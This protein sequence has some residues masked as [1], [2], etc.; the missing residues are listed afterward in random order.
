[1]I[2][3]IYIYFQVSCFNKVSRTSGIAANMVTRM[4]EPSPVKKPRIS[5]KAAD[6]SFLEYSARNCSAADFGRRFAQLRRDFFMPAPSSIQSSNS[7]VYPTA[8]SAV[9]KVDPFNRSRDRMLPITPPESPGLLCLP[10]PSIASKSRIFYPTQNESQISGQHTHYPEA[11]SSISAPSCDDISCFSGKRDHYPEVHSNAANG[12]P[13]DKRRLP[14][15]MLANEEAECLP[16]GGGCLQVEEEWERMLHSPI[17]GYR[18]GDKVKKS[19][20]AGSCLHEEQN[21]GDIC[22]VPKKEDSEPLQTAMSADDKFTSNRGGD[23]HKKSPVAKS[24]PAKEPN[25]RKIC[26]VPKRERGEPLKTAMNAE[27]EFTSTMSEENGKTFQ[28][29]DSL[30]PKGLD[31]EEICFVPKRGKNGPLKTAMS[32]DNDCK[33]NC[34]TRNDKD[35][36]EE[37]SDQ[38][39]QTQTTLE[40][41]ERN[42]ESSDDANTTDTDTKSSITDPC[43]LQDILLDDYYHCS[44]PKVKTEPLDT[45]T[46]RRHEKVACKIYGLL[47]VQG[48]RER[49]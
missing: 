48:T 3:K 22:L 24:L 30:L 13:N 31:N 39:Q 4:L 25:N 44:I 14:D 9:C 10:I 38:K 28:S 47:S 34:L 33:S 20:L 2:I 6:Q 49:R 18:E 21:N 43:P 32:A 15:A 23:E 35:K 29:V 11:C 42:T 17:F 36:D 26:Q 37:R 40:S 27:C 1:M 5:C 16:A 7:I 8:F 41:T 19:P 12:F 45:K 46:D